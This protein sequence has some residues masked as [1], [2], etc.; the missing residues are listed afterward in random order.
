MSKLKIPPPIQGLFWAF[1]MW[2][3]SRLLPD[4]NYRFS[5]Q[6]ILGFLFIGAGLFLDLLSIKSFWTAKTTINPL[7]PEKA[8][9]LVISG[10]Y[11]FSRNPMYLGLAMLLIGWS[12]LLGNPINLIVIGCF[13]GAMNVFQ[14]KPEE[15]ALKSKFG[16]EYDDYARRVRRWI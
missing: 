12:V 14:I 4:L 16:N 2:G 6:T 10:F 15:A 5:F 7:N 3:I 8:S 11:R 13:I 1:C 9:Q